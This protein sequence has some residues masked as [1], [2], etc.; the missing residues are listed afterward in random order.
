[1]CFNRM[2]IGFGQ[3]PTARAVIRDMIKTT[4]LYLTFI[5][6]KKERIRLYFHVKPSVTCAHIFLTRE[7]DLKHSFLE[8]RVNNSKVIVDNWTSRIPVMLF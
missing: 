7:T 2:P 3:I 1:M 6:K 4:V 5:F 8:A